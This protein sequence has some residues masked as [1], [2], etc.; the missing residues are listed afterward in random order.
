MFAG[1]PGRGRQPKPPPDPHARIVELVTLACESGGSA[2]DPELLR[3]LKREVRAD[4]VALRRA[5]D[6]LMDRCLR[7]RECG[8]RLHAVII[9]DELFRRSRDFRDAHMERL[10]AFLRRAIVGRDSGADPSEAIPGPV[11]D[12][13]RLVSRACRAL[14]EWNERFGAHYPRLAVALR[15]VDDVLGPA[16][17]A[18]I[19]ERECREARR[20]DDEERARRLGRWR[21]CERERLPGLRRDAG[22]Y[23]VA[24]GEC[25][26]ILLGA[27]PSSSSRFEHDDDDER[28]DRDAAENGDDDED[29]ERWEDVDADEP[30]DSSPDDSSPGGRD[31]DPTQAPPPPPLRII[32]PG[33]TTAGDLVARLGGDVRVAVTDDNRVVVDELR[34]LCRAATVRVLPGLAEALALVAG[35]H[36]IPADQ[37]HRSADVTPAVN[38]ALSSE[39]KAA[40]V[41][42]LARCKRTLRAAVDRC[43]ALGVVA[44]SDPGGGGGV[45]TVV[46]ATEAN[47]GGRVGAND[48]ASTPAPETTDRALTIALDDAPRLPTEATL[49]DGA[50]PDD[51]EG[52]R[53]SDVDALIERARRRRA[54]REGLARRNA[55]AGDG[56]GNGYGNRDGGRGTKLRGGAVAGARA[57]GDANG[58]AA[59]L[60][61]RMLASAMREHN[62]SVMRELGDE[63]TER[64]DEA[65]G[66]AGTRRRLERER[67]EAEAREAE[68]AAKEAAKRRRRETTTKQR[69]EAKLKALRR[70]RR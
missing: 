23:A 8:P 27:E 58:S 1:R 60:A 62:E 9:V 49:T 41:N 40:A 2:P 28:D 64:R 70:K 54:R 24:I 3:A 37:D 59:N 68:E 17:P 61:K 35:I 69:I 65:S 63:Y 47:G 26:A 57:A 15:F 46:A 13:D 32:P 66:L 22:E 33:Q 51:G 43:V 19:A 20:R 67:E 21:R 7:H 5:H 38:D 14:Q 42:A 4:A 48:D 30:D 36:S 45:E 50:I 52:A 12:A 56:N 34:R 6:T 25:L 10:D 39:S 53:G 11:E 55:A 18:S 16:A 29:D 44:G 31:T